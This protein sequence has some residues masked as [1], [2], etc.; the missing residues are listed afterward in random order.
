MS[1]ASAVPFAE[2]ATLACEAE[3]LEGL[4]IFVEYDRVQR[5]A[6]YV[7]HATAIAPATTFVTKTSPLR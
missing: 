6:M 5:L 3:G 4:Q 7:G 2:F 1:T